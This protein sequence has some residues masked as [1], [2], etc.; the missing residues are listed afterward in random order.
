MREPFSQSVVKNHP[1]G[2]VFDPIQ[3][4]SRFLSTLALSAAVLFSSAYSMQV[5][6]K[7]EGVAAPAYSIESAAASAGLLLDV[8]RA[9]KRLVA[10]GDRG[11]I[12]YSDDEGTQWLQ[13]RVPTQQL[14]TAVYFIDDRYGWAV[15]HDALILATRDGGA[16]WTRQFDDIER[17]SPLLDIWFKDRN[18]GYAVGA[19]G[20]FLET[21][22]GGQDWQDIG[23]RLDNEEGY[24]L[25]AISAVTGAGLFIVGE[26]GS[27]FRSTD[28]G[29]SWETV[30][31]PYEGS[32]FGIVS[33]RK[34]DHLI[35]YGLRGHIFRS[36]NLGE[37][38]SA[39][40]VHTDS[41]NLQFG[42]ADGSL[43]DN[44][45]LLVVGH[46]GTI[47]RSVNDGQSFTVFN[48]ADRTSLAGVTS[49]ANGGL[50]LVGQN[51]IHRT[52]ANGNDLLAQ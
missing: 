45:D 47:L 28:G 38:W 49:G 7:A 14:L 35:V 13:A 52:D 17:E 34:A 23:D 36:T 3:G 42:L 27:M 19:Y 4:C 26:M 32:L 5:S 1:A 31:S 15:G 41:G 18:T 21:T 29:A 25:N 8:T 12:L 30:D 46:G 20:A 50:I 6:A 37:T 43:L 33:G 11:H 16:T 51:G 39:T 10:V 48:R 24:H 9:G 44:G 2:R 40:E 22:N